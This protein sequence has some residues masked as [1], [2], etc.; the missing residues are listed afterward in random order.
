MVGESIL[1]VTQ[2]NS[3]VHRP[4][5]IDK[6]GPRQHTK[7]GSTCH[8]DVVNIVDRRHC[9]HQATGAEDGATASK[10]AGEVFGLQLHEPVLRE[11]AEAIMKADDIHSVCP[12]GGLP[13]CSDGSVQA[14]AI[15]AC[16]ENADSS[17]H[18]TMVSIRLPAE[19][20][21][22][23]RECAGDC[24]GP[25]VSGIAELDKRLGPETDSPASDGPD[26]PS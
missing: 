2:V 10:D 24:I 25:G 20:R 6:V 21:W 8:Q 1:D 19:T 17:R 22:L 4:V 15:T 12:L 13:D 3:G 9:T 5:R 18:K 16:G 7:V 11:T 14:W 26:S 23:T